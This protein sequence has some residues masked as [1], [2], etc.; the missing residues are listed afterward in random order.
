MVYQLYLHI[1]WSF[2][3]PTESGIRMSS[4]C[5]LASIQI[6]SMWMPFALLLTF[7]NKRELWI[8]I[9][10]IGGCLFTVILALAATMLLDRYKNAGEVRKE[11]I[12]ATAAYIKHHSSLPGWIMSVES[13]SE[14]CCG[15]FSPMDIGTRFPMTEN[16]RKNKKY[17]EEVA[18]CFGNVFRVIRNSKENQYEFT[19]DVIGKDPNYAHGCGPLFKTKARL[20]CYFNVYCGLVI[21]VFALV[22]IGAYIIRVLQGHPR[23]RKRPNDV[24][25]VGSGTTVNTNTTVTSQPQEKSEDPLEVSS[26]ITSIGT[27][28]NPSEPIY[29][30]DSFTY[31]VVP[32]E[33]PDPA[34][35]KKKSKK[36]KNKIPKE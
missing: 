23:K 13:S 30:Q 32:I 11:Y 6:F 33:S 4:W 20:I 21:A 1:A 7:W 25:K 34:P 10:Y 36:R 9:V 14:R 18:D 26:S 27:D 31:G 29:S 12:S 35:K 22:F 8:H 28:V 15:W 5:L 2:N 24:E 3:F 19:N 17:M 16:L